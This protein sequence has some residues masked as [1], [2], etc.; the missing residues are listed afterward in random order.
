MMCSREPRLEPS[1]PIPTSVAAIPITRTRASVRT[2]PDRDAPTSRTPAMIAS[3][4]TIMLFRH[5]SAASDRA[6]MSAS[7]SA[8][9]RWMSVIRAR[10]KSTCLEQQSNLDPGQREYR[11]SCPSQTQ[12]PEPLVACHGGP[13]TD[14]SPR[15][16]SRSSAGR[17][18]TAILSRQHKSGYQRA[19]SDLGALVRKVTPGGRHG[20]IGGPGRTG[21]SMPK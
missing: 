18:T 5:R 6:S 2:N 1:R 16:P 14:R 4:A 20:K 9:C 21:S 17:G 8:I 13:R 10:H 3:R 12:S 19:A 15:S 11:G 7:R